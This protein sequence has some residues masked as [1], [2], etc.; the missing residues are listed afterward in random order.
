MYFLLV[1]ST[2]DAEKI[3]QEIQTFVKNFFGK[4]KEDLTPEKFAQIKESVRVKTITP[5]NNLNKLFDFVSN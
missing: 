1:S 4:M 2:I 5:H 3:S